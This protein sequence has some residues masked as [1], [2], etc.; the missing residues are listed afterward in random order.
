MEAGGADGTPSLWIRKAPSKDAP[1]PLRLVSGEEAS[2]SPSVPAPE[3]LV[4]S[5]F[6]PLKLM[7]PKVSCWVP[8]AGVPSPAGVR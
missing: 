1:L 8:N 5:P 7:W 4:V 2:S 3:R 6:V